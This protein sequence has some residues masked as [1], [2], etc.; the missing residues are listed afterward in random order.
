[1]R[2]D[3][4]IERH[5]Q[6]CCGYRSLLLSYLCIGMLLFIFLGC[7]SD[8]PEGNEKP[9][10]GQTEDLS[11]AIPDA[12]SE[13]SLKEMFEVQGA[14]TLV[15]YDTSNVQ[16][17]GHLRVLRS[18]NDGGLH[19]CAAGVYTI[20]IFRTIPEEYSVAAESYGVTIGKAYI[21]SQA[22]QGSFI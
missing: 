1:M 6:A 17:T 9:K 12:Q 11:N 8:A 21:L 10:D 7:S 18:H 3:I 20:V 15:I 22:N 13:P 16:V 2:N 4:Q 19:L 5:N 14:E